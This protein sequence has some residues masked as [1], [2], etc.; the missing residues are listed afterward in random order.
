MYKLAF[1]LHGKGKSS[2]LEEREERS[3]KTA[4]EMIT[5]T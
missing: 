4:A 2:G 1:G 3:D 5:W